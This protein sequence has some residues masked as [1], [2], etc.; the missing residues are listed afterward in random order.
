LRV[1][2]Q[3]TRSVSSYKFITTTNQSGSYLSVYSLG[4]IYVHRYACEVLQPRVGQL[5]ADNYINLLAVLCDK[6]GVVYMV[7]IY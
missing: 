2:Q 6:T 3:L 5:K 1:R 7:K 4:W